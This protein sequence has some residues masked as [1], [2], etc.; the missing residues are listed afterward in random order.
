MTPTPPAAPFTPYV[1][2][3]L[4]TRIQNFCGMA[5]ARHSKRLPAKLAY[6]IG[7]LADDAVRLN[8]AESLATLDARPSA[9]AAEALRGEVERAREANR[10]LREQQKDDYARAD[11]AEA[12]VSTLKDKVAEGNEA[13][14]RVVK[15]RD[16]A[17]AEVARVRGLTRWTVSRDGLN[18]H[19][20]GEWISAADVLACFDAT[21][22]ASSPTI[23]ELR[24]RFVDALARD[25]ASTHDGP[26]ADAARALADAVKEG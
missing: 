6:E 1:V 5:H 16:S 21:P 3:D 7:R 9:P 23:A 12:D 4:L 11:K 26:V 25:W 14:F 15:E 24:D 10:V 17:R 19:P 8:T 20:A 18:A 2:R 22:T 13:Y